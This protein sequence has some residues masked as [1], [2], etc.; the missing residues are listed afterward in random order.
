M[1]LACVTPT[2]G[3]GLSFSLMAMAEDIFSTI[4][5]FYPTLIA[6]TASEICGLLHISRLSLTGASLHLL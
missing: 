4:P 5:S 1:S 3:L 6:I 2:C